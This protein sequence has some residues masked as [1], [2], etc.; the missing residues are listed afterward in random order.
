MNIEE[1][2]KIRGNQK[3]DKYTEK[4]FKLPLFYRIPYWTKILTPAALL[5]AAS[6][7]SIVNF[8]PKNN[9]STI[10]L[11]VSDDDLSI[12]DSEKAQPSSIYYS[13]ES[14][15]PTWNELSMPEKYPESRDCITVRWE[16]AGL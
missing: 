7:I 8:M 14:E 1:L 2:I 12:V 4:K 13:S 5:L 3:I 6:I 15:V 16:S 11:I 9:N 10:N